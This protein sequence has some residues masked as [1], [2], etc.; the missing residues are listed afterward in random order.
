MG[1][2]SR[3][4]RDGA[5]SGGDV[6]SL[7]EPVVTALGLDLEDLDVQASGRRRRVSVVIDRD[8]GVDL[9]GI[10]A[11]SRA[12]SDALDASD[13]MGDDPY[14][15]EVTSPGVDRPLTLPR[16]WRRNMGRRVRVHLADGSTVDGR[17]REVDDNGVL[18]AVD[19]KGKPESM[20]R[21]TPWAEVVR[22]EVQ[23]EFRRPQGPDSAGDSDESA[24]DSG[25][26]AGDSG[27]SSSEEEA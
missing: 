23:V 26:S 17:I 4:A 12:V 15:L 22:G 1:R 24:G 18:V 3:G 16:H 14:T 8:G 27:E 6:R 11:A 21:R 10:A 2:P 9:D 20:E 13:A 5:G 25:E 7:L 19:V